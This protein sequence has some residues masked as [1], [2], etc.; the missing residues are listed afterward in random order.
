MK[1]MMERGN[2]FIK[3]ARIF[4]VIAVILAAIIYFL[5]SK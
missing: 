1:V 4:L 5:T 2:A 3:K